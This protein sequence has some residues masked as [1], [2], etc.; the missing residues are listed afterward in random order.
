MTVG[1]VLIPGPV[2]RTGHHASPVP[3]P[4]ARDVVAGQRSSRLATP[5]AAL[6]DR[7]AAIPTNGVPSILPVA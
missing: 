3:V 4:Q 5:T 2:P 7:Q 6:Q 1:G